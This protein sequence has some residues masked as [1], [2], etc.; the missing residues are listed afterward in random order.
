MAAPTPAEVQ[1]LGSDLE[2]LS[3]AFVQQYIDIAECLISEDAWGDCGEK[4]LL[5]MSAHLAALGARG[6]ASGSVSSE[7]VGDLQKSYSSIN[8][9][10]KDVNELALTSYGMMLSQ[11]R[12]TL[13]VTPFCV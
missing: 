13:L 6:G 9:L 4:A 7:K 8:T 12:R 1:A 3:D 10:G 2:S 11:L 5:L